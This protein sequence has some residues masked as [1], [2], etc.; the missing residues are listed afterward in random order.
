[1]EGEKDQKLTTHRIVSIRVDKIQ[2]AHKQ[3]FPFKV[4]INNL[5]R[6]IFSCISLTTNI[7]FCQ[8]VSLEFF[9]CWALFS[10]RN[11][12]GNST[13]ALSLLFGN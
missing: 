1:M 2:I 6:Q 13:V 3:V 8:Q 5:S 7:F 12:L 4:T 11:F 10:W 9:W